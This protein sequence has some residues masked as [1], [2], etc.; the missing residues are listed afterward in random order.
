M[1]TCVKRF[2]QILA[3]PGQI[4]LENGWG[5][6]HRDIQDEQ[7]KQGL[8]EFDMVAYYAYALRKQEHVPSLVPLSLAQRHPL[9]VSKLNFF[10]PQ[11]ECGQDEQGRFRRHIWIPR[12]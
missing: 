9:E 8:D 6:R 5:S 7:C 3:L 2:D 11:I 4:S 12:R 10:N 1:K